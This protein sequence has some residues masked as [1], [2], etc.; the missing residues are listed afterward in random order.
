MIGRSDD[1]QVTHPGQKLVRRNPAVGATYH[2]C[3]WIALWQ[4]HKFEVLIRMNRSQ[5]GKPVI[6]VY[7]FSKEFEGY[8]SGPVF[9]VA[10]SQPNCEGHN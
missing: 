7:E 4:H 2:H 9:F 6:P 5:M 10:D 3:K 1:K 8:V